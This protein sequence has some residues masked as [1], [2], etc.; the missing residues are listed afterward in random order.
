MYYAMGPRRL[1]E[2]WSEA[3]R[4]TRERCAQ[5]AE[6]FSSVGVTGNLCKRMAERIR[7]KE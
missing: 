2:A 1:Y 6:G 7:G 4:D 3:E 5:I